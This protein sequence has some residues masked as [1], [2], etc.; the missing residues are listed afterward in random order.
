[1]ANG[2]DPE[3]KS[4]CPVS[5]IYDGE[6]QCCDK[7][8]QEEDGV[9]GELE[10]R[11]GDGCCVG[12]EE[13]CESEVGNCKD[14]CCGD[15]EEHSIVE[16]PTYKEDCQGNDGVP[17]EAESHCGGGCCA[18]DEGDRESSIENCKDS[19]C[20]RGEDSSVVEKFVCEDPQGTGPSVPALEGVSC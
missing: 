5:A 6:V 4:P 11:C 17:G 8:H 18:D 15:G 2:G 13:D 20:G 3:D 19:C 12:D 16:E 10:S 9:S 1:M 7:D 14:S